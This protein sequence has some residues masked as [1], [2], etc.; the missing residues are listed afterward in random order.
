[1][2][3]PNWFPCDLHQLS[4]MRFLFLQ[5]HNSLNICGLTFSV[6][7][8]NSHKLPHLFALRSRSPSSW[9]LPCP[10]PRAEP[11]PWALRVLPSLGTLAP[12]L[13]CE[14]GPMCPW[15][16][17]V[18]E[19][20]CWEKTLIHATYPFQVNNS[21]VFSVLTGPRNYHAS[22]VLET[23]ITSKRNAG[24]LATIRCPLCFPVLTSHQHPFLSL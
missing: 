20:L 12:L 2:L 24:H 10:S 14:R 1:M 15:V 11:Q 23:S 21:V 22:Q 9:H 7:G 17:M 6:P 3:I 13:F 16:I 5:R 8:I 4:R 18:F 19:W